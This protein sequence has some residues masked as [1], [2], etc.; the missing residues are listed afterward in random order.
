[1]DSE[2]RLQTAKR[3]TIFKQPISVLDM[4]F[5]YFAKLG[6]HSIWKKNSN[7]QA[8]PETLNKKLPESVADVEVGESL[9]L[10]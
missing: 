4:L 8:L 9:N 1:M 7:S 10:Y 3:N 2:Q 6:D 5:K